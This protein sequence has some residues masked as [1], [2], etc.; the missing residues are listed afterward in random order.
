MPFIENF[1]EFSTR[2][3]CVR[4]RVSNGWLFENGAVVYD[5]EGAYEPPIDPIELLTAQI[6]FKEAVVTRTK[7]KYRRVF[8]ATNAQA[9]YHRMGAGNA[10]NPET[11]KY[12]KMLAKILVIQEQSLEEMK[13][14]L[15]VTDTQDSL[16][17]YRAEEKARAN[18]IIGQLQQLPTF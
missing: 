12:L 8:N 11:L 1:D 2:Q 18:D 15:P 16:E 13:S 7:A 3:N 4:V 6:K 14:K 9:E 10:P 17:M 5:T